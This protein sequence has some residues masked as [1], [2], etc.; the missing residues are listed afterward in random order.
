MQIQIIQTADPVKYRPIIRATERVNRLYAKLHGCDYAATQ[1][2]VRGASPVHAAFNR[3]YLMDRMLEA[4]YRGWIAYLDSDAYFGDLYFDLSAYLAENAA[5]CFIAARASADTRKWAINNGVFFVN[6][7][8]PLG[9]RLVRTYRQYVDSLV[10][11][12]YWEQTDA[13]W[14]PQEYD[15][16]NILFSVLAND[17][18][19]LDSMKNEDRAFNC[20]AG[21]A[22]EQILREAYPTFEE[23]VQAL[24]R[25]CDGV[26]NRFVQDINPFLVKGWVAG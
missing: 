5:H 21:S 25:A 7:D 10:P 24:E 13:A 8:H 11:Q 14:P 23:R 9:Q 18:E 16:Q 2:I 1:E 15:D 26:I 12:S 17:A 3:V 22:I 19:I 6:L 20:G 4:G